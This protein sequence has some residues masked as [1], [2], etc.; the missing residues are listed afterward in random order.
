MNVLLALSHSVE[1]YDQL[2]LLHSLGYT[3]ASIGGYIDPAHPHTAMRPPL[4]DVPAV[5]ELR[6]AVD[7]LG[8]DDNLGAAQSRLPDVALE[9]ADIIIYHHYLGRLFGQWPRIRDWMDGGRRV[10]W[11]TVG[12]SVEGN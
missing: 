1:E 8:T 5:P 2:R 7:A 12:Q 3:V 4:P 11:R 10:V 6:A 9:W